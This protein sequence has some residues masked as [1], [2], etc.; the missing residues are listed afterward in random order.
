[1]IQL[2]DD[3]YHILIFL[4]DVFNCKCLPLYNFKRFRNI[5]IFRHSIAVSIMMSQVCHNVHNVTHRVHT[6]VEQAQFNDML[7]LLYNLGIMWD[8]PFH[9]YLD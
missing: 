9:P 7:R 8:V 6:M 5:F 1:M 4:N 3:G 2:V